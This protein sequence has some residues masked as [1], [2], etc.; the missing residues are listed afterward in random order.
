MTVALFRK[1]ALSMP[2]AV[3][4]SHMGHPDFR[5]NGRIFATLFVPRDQNRE[6]GRPR[7]MCG[8]VKLTPRQQREFVRDFPNVFEQISGGWGVRG[9]TQVR[10]SGKPSPSR[11]LLRRAILTA[12]RNTAP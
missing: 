2:D 7:R 3:E 6:G 5:V 11:T 9:A 1:I 10:L 8:M 4:K 12:W